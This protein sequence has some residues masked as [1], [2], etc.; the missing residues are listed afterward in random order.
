M[1]V[2]NLLASTVA[3][4]LLLT[5]PAAAA[6]P[7]V[8]VMVSQSRGASAQVELPEGTLWISV[9]ESAIRS[10]AG[11]QDRSAGGYAEL[12]ITTCD[13]GECTSRRSSAQLPAESVHVSDDLSR[14]T[15]EPTEIE[16]ETVV[17]TWSDGWD[18]GWDDAWDD[19]WNDGWDDGWDDDGW[20]DGWDDAWDDGWNDGW[21]DG[22]DDG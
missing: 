20:D 14:A 21:D 15:L 22:W 10:N 5:A 13:D 6:Q 9:G 16:V 17:C 8:A 7:G 4:L 1:H 3:C 18:D 2:K 19:G 11:W 12:E